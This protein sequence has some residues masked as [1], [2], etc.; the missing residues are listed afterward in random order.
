[1]SS[2]LETVLLGAARGVRR[3]NLSRTRIT[4]VA[5]RL[6]P[7]GVGTPS[8]FNF[9]AALRADNSDSPSNTLRSPSARSCA[10]RLYALSAQPTYAHA[11]GFGALHSGLGPFAD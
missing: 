2:V 3:L 11:L 8:A 9:S 6:P 4:C 10:S 7:A 5:C 1:M